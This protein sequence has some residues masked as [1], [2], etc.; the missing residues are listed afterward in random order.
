MS[1]EE[2]NKLFGTFVNI[3]QA[4]INL[5][6]SFPPDKID[7]IPNGFRNNIYWN[8][9][10]ILTVQISL[11]YRRLKKPLP[12]D[13]SYFKYFGKGT[14]PEDWDDKMPPFKV[15]RNQLEKITD[16]S[17]ADLDRYENLI[18]PEPFTVT[19]GIILTTFLEGLTFLAIHE[20]YHLGAINAMKKVL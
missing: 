16:K 17:F 4:N 11:F 12:V 8:A 7:V 10:H 18:Y 15:V 6:D 5:I 9:G 19:G 1:K 3:R 14:S 13:D 2:T 20:S